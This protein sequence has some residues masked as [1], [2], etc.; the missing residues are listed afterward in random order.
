M[1]LTG[2]SNPVTDS[3][4]S[5]SGAWGGGGGGGGQQRPLFAWNSIATSP[6]RVIYRSCLSLS[7]DS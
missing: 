4:L 5:F 1:Q 2:S 7:T 6:G 3:I